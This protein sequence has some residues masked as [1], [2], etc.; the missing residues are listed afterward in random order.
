MCQQ[1]ESRLLMTIDFTFV[2]AGGNTIGF[3]D[4]VNGSTYRS[5]LESCADTLGTWF[6]TD[7]T[8]KIRVTSES[9]PSGNWL[10]S[11]SPID[12]SVVHTQGFN[13]GGI[14]W[15]KATGGGDA[16][17][18]GNDAN[19]EVNFANSFATGLGVGAGQED[20]VATYMHELMH[21]IG[22]V[23]NVTQGGGSY[24][25]TST[26]WSL[27]DKYLS[28]ANG[29]PIINQTTFVLNKTLWNTV[30]VGGTSP[31]T[32]L[33]FNGPNARAANGNQPVALYS[34][35]VW[36]QGSS[37]G[38]HVRDNSG[39]IN[40]DDYLMVAN[41]VSGRVNG[42]VLNPVEFAM[43]KDA[44]LNM[45]QPG[46]DLVQ[47]D[48]ST[49]VT[50]SGG[51]DTFSVRL[52][53]RPLAN[54]I[55]NVG[56]SNAGEVSLDKL[57]LTFTPDNWNVPQIVTA[58][59]VA[60]HQIDPDAA[61]GID[62][63]FA[64]R[65][66]TYK[67]AGTAAFTATNVNADFPVP[68]RTYVVT[69]LLDQPLNGAGDTDGLLS[70]REA[71]AAANANSAFG[72]ALPGS[73]DFADSITFAPELGGG[74]I[75]LGGVLSIT[76][77]LTITGPGAGSQTID[78]QN[79]YQIFNIALTDFTGQVNI[80]GLTLTNGNNS[81]GGAVFSLG[82]D[83]ALS[84]MSFQ[85]N[86][87][88]YQGGAVFQ[89]TGALS[90]T[91]SVF[92]GNTADDG[93]GAIHADGGPLLEIHRSTFTGNTAKYGG[94]IDSFA[95][96]LILQDST[97]SGNFASSLGGAMILDN[98]SAKI[99]N[100]TLVLNSAGG[101]GG[102]IY[103][104][105]GEL[106]LRNTTVVGNR[107]NA[108]NIPGGNGGGVWTFNATDTSTAI[109]N[110]IVAGNY[111]GL[112]LNANQTMGSADEFKGKALVAMSSHNIIGTTS[113]AG[114]LTNGTNGNLLAVNWTTVVANLLVSG[115]KAPDLKNN[116][117]PTKT[118]ALIANSPALNAGNA[119]EAVDASGNALASDQR[120]TGFLR[121]SGSTI[122]IGA[123]ET[124]V[125]VAPVIASFDGNVAFAGPAVVLDADA[126]VSD[127]D[128]LDF[129]AGKLT[130]SLTANG[131]GSDVLA[132]R[133]QGTGTGQIGV[134]DSNVTF[135]GVVIG[136]FTG[137]K[138]K[139]GLSITFNANA[140]PSAVQALLRNITFINSTATRSTVTRTVRVIVT[141]GDGGT[142]VAVTKS[143]TV[144][145]PNDPPVVGAFAGGV[146]YS[147][148]GNAVAL[149]DDATVNDA[150]SA[151]FDSGTLTISLTAN[152]QSTDVL[153]IR[154]D[155]TGAG[156]IG[157]SGGNVSFGGVTIGTFTG[158]TSKVGLKIT[159]NAS[160]TPVAIQ[161]L[162]RAITFK[163]TLANPVTTARTVR[164][165]L[166]DGD[167]GT[168]AA[169]TKA[170][171]I[172]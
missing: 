23:S 15:I 51:T 92:N 167:G 10:A 98:S 138:N 77:D 76:D 94:A 100:S 18:T 38:S 105:R 139:V 140:T 158:G 66:D 35:A 91:D 168:S 132:I 42:R 135:A 28:D 95:N 9:D 8:I 112:T 121:S 62:L 48:G 22:F 155:G 118:V 12:T 6:E 93:G 152:G 63:T 45:V 84:G 43:M 3:N 124:Q 96:E 1:L 154:N 61:V 86:H 127:S 55:V 169:V 128:S 30:K 21:A 47:T 32:G 74:T 142:S 109:Y 123:F 52:K 64:Q 162:L 17:G 126:T 78:G 7:T 166:T 73:P 161:A 81:M 53:T 82:A 70:L 165:I 4:P 110:S 20:L 29:T 2:Y 41:G 108:D 88:S 156:Q 147:P 54:V 97:L 24:F 65:D 103:N 85:S 106:V 151:N 163:S 107:A 171:N 134:S 44:G 148:G 87:A 33:F 137:G 59:G 83:L 72:D 146:N 69:T 67:F 16:N 34:P 39:S 5:Q 58:T 80:S 130:V 131:Q 46:L 120:G 116:G 153:A 122:D 56:N 144:A 125:N 49:I 90:V 150:D 71:L 37:D 136:T 89:M 25:D 164:A 11:A 129:S 160:S 79:L 133:N 60:D 36:A 172:V 143:I 113:S 19:I 99:S 115:I 141:D 117:G 31:S 27:Y 159:F 57:Q 75:S 101:N 13:N 68:A 14:P 170:I 157:V 119:N 104:E 145:A 102:A 26:Q 40:V 50:E 111:T 149:D 114:G